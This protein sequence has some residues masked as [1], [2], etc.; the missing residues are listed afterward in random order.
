MKE[1]LKELERKVTETSAALHH[2]STTAPPVKGKDTEDEDAADKDADTDD[3]IDEVEEKEETAAVKGGNEKVDKELDQVEDANK[4]AQAQV[5]GLVKTITTVQ[6]KS[7]ASEKELI[8]E[9]TDSTKEEQEAS[10]LAE[11]KER[12]E[13]R[14]ERQRCARLFPDVF[15]SFKIKKELAQENM[16][17]CPASGKGLTILYLENLRDAG[18]FDKYVLG[19]FENNLLVDAAVEATIQVHKKDAEASTDEAK[20]LKLVVHDDKLEQV[21]QALD[22]LSLSMKSTDFKISPLLQGK[23]EYMKWQQTSQIRPEK[24]HVVGGLS[25]VEEDLEEESLDE[26]PL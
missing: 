9:I 25:E 8:Q 14:R 7:E 11:S 1:V 6:E 12:L 23:T 21:E 4:A 18:E 26:I 15:G 5:D 2:T 24:K 13:R 20:R 3:K 16:C 10:E 22:A 19:L 17:P